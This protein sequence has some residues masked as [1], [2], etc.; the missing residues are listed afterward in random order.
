VIGIA[1]V[2]AFAEGTIRGP[3]D[4]GLRH[5]FRTYLTDRFLMQVE[6]RRFVVFT[7]GDVQ[8]RRRMDRRR[9]LFL[10]SV[11]VAGGA[12]TPVRAQVRPKPLADPRRRRRSSSRKSSDELSNRRRPHGN[13]EIGL[14]QRDQHRGFR[15][16]R[17]LW[18][19]LPTRHEHFAEAVVRIRHRK[20]K[21]QNSRG[22]TQLLATTSAGSHYYDLPLA[23]RAVRCSSAAARNAERRVR[24]DGQAA[25]LCR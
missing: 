15:R 5:R 9:R 2:L 25:P 7:S 4:H 14:Y 16:A 20:D 8:E 17:R 6:Y 23:E 19:A 3:L 22:A 24:D 21:L 13:F 11:A 1:G 12:G 18:L 10:L